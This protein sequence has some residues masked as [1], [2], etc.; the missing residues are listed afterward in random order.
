MEQVWQEY[1]G[2][3]VYMVNCREDEY[4]SAIGG[5]VIKYDKDKRV[6]YKEIGKHPGKGHQ[7]FSYIG[8]IP[9]RLGVFV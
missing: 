5:E 1:D 9:D 3:W 4:G 2:Y 7:F 6:I 8:K